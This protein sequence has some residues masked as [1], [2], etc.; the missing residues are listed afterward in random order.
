[1]AWVIRG[2][3]TGKG[4]V[5]RLM[6][7]AAR[8]MALAAVLFVS[9]VAALSGGSASG[10]SAP[11][12]QASLRPP[13]S[14]PAATAAG[15]WTQADYNA[16][17][18]R[19][20]PTERVLTRATAPGLRWLRS[21]AAPPA[22]QFGCRSQVASPVLSGGSIYA[23]TGDWLS[24]YSA[25]TGRLIWR[26]AS[27]PQ[28]GYAGQSL[29]VVSGTAVVASVYCF[30][31]SDPFGLIQTFS[32]ATGAPGW[33]AHPL[34]A[35]NLAVSGG[36]VVVAGDVAGGSEVIAYHLTNGAR[37]WAIEDSECP[38][39][40]VDG[41]SAPAAALVTSGLAVGYACPETGGRHLAAWNLHTGARVWNRTG[42][43]WTLQRGDTATGTARH[44]YAIN[45]AGTAVA[46]D[47]HTGKTLY[48]LPGA[49]RVLA[50]DASRAYA[51][52]HSDQALEAVCAYALSDGRL[53][54]NAPTPDGVTVTLAAEAAGVLY[55]SQGQA[56]NTGTGATLTTLWDE[57]SPAATALAVGGGHI[58]AVTDPRVLD[59][60]GLPHPPQ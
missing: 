38:S 11:G 13:A 30:S 48:S 10:G 17:L 29:A 2:M 8:P 37:A 51:Q 5:V 42:G 53:L 32:S 34:A 20:N 41:H 52:C 27:S 55:T 26:A 6:R 31:N 12:R 28:P 19:A 44:L 40:P 7:H 16:A 21:M 36:M 15:S 3:P 35:F 23:A 49:S 22:P 4:N 60:Y 18:S 57:D 54:W 24:K 56:L 45:P 46:L 33:T 43:N 1:M 39:L 59:I 14:S 47:P 9:P 25:S 50:V 58:A